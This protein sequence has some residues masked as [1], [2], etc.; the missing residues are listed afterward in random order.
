MNYRC[1]KT[2]LLKDAYSG[3]YDERWEVTEGTI[4][5]KD[6]SGYGLLDGEARLLRR[7][8]KETDE[9]ASVVLLEENISN[10]FE[11]VK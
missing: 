4:W 10:Y 2:F 9:V 11:P 7:N 6:C 3:L 8:L 5:T 1:K